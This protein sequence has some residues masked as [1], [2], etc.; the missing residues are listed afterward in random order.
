MAWISPTRRKFL[1]F[2]ARCLGGL[3]LAAAGKK[4]PTEAGAKMGGK[5]TLF[6]PA[7]GGGSAKFIEPAWAGDGFDFAKSGVEKTGGRHDMQRVTAPKY[8]ACAPSGGLG[9]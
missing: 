3:P 2:N 9:E 7:W 4:A 5:Q 1:T 6:R 8:R